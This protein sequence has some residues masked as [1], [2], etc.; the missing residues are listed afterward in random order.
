MSALCQEK[1][2]F[3]KVIVSTFFS[4]FSLW[5]IDHERR[6]G[7]KSCSKNKISKNALTRI[8]TGDL[9]FTS[10]ASYHRRLICIFWNKRRQSILNNYAVITCTLE[11]SQWWMDDFPLLQNT[12]YVYIHCWW[13][14]ILLRFI[15]SKLREGNPVSIQT[16][17]SAVITLEN[18]LL[19][20]VTNKWY[21]YCWYH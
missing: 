5:C 9:L 18:G 1:I 6:I 7:R 8:W 4:H 20:Y 21:V 19:S 11:S 15:C 3:T 12:C 13:Y 2:D 16:G 17:L 10:Q 14:H